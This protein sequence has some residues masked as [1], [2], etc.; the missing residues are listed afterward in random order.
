MKKLLL[1][2]FIVFLYLTICIFY[3]WPLITSFDES[4]ISPDIMG[5]SSSYIWDI[6]IFKSNFFNNQPI[7]HTQQILSP[8]GGNLIMHGYMPALCLYSLM[9]ENNLLALNSFIFLHFVLSAYGAY[10]LSFY[11]NKNHL[12]S[13][14][15]GFIFSF[16]AYKM[17]R[18]SEHYNLVLT[19]T[20][21]FYIFFFI[22]TFDFRSKSFIPRIT[23]YKYLLYCFLLGIVSVLND[24][25]A[26]FYLIYFSITWIVFFKIYPYWSNLPTIKKVFYPILFLVSMHLI[27]EP[28]L[29]HGIDDKG[30]FWWGGNML[31]YFIPN[32]N[33]WLYNNQ[34]LQPLTDI[35]YFER[36]SYEYQLF[37]GY[38]V[39]LCVFYLFYKW[40][41]KSLP[42]EIK[43]WLFISLFFFFLTTPVIYFGSQ[44]IIYSPTSIIHFIPFFNNI[45]CNTRA[46]VM[47]ELSIPIATS[48]VW[49]VFMKSKNNKLFSTY[50]PFLFLLFAF[51]EFK[52]NT[53]NLV[54]KNNI[55]IVYQEIKNSPNKYLTTM[56]TGIMDGLKS[57]GKFNNLEQFYQ[58]EHHKKITGGYL[59]RVSDD[60]FDSYL[61]DSVMFQLFIYS[62]DKN[63]QLHIPSKP[64][65]DKYFNTFNTDMFLITP[66]Y[67]NSNAEK[68]IRFLIQDKTYKTK[69]VSNYLYIEISN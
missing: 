24:Y 26:T 60:V 11:L 5:D 59:S 27:I 22:Q 50:I 25:Y 64:T 31:S 54:N 28:M 62:Q 38:G 23:S 37:L 19:A 15:V 17:L 6:Y 39:L 68:F 3:T 21:P 29:I 46:I 9:F 20:I 56:P 16:S 14:I 63:A 35:A 48:I 43:P 13:F 58:T 61:K 51:L 44:K 55:P 32:N 33:S 66:D 42:E 4:F 8:I 40:F 41:Q 18:L 45:R 12:L 57:Y 47:L 67:R 34:W 2:L 10:K 53:Y 30:G 65:I 36:N 52:P 49:C 1:E 7:F 69:S